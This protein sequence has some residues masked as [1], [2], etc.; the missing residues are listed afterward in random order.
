MKPQKIIAEHESLIFGTGFIVL[1]LIVWETIPLW[2]TLPRGMALFFTTP[3]RIAAA[4]YQLLL[5]GTI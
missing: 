1:L 5:D 4:F 2:Y 3:S